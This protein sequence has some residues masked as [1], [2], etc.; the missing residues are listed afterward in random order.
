MS[1]SGEGLLAGL[2]A[3][4]FIDTGVS[5][6]AIVRRMSFSP[7][8]PNS[9]LLGSAGVPPEAGGVSANASAVLSVLEEPAGIAKIVERT[10]LTRRQAKYA[11]DSLVRVRAVAVDGGQGNRFTR[12]RRA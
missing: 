6:T 12:Y 10:A 11:L 1:W 4:S 2:P 8:S 3:L 5:F 7:P 9:E